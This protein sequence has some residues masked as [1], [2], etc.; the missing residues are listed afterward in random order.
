LAVTRIMALAAKLETHF[1][2]ETTYDRAK[3]RENT[4]LPLT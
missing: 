3:K 2:W 4:K 1:L